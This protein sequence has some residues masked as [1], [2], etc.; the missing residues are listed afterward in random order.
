[1][2]FLIFL[3][4]IIL[5]VCFV[6]R[7][8]IGISMISCCIIYFLV[9]GGN[10][11]VI[12]DTVMNQL[13]YNSVLIAAPLFIFTANIMNSSK[14]TQH[15]FTFCKA[16]VGNKRGAMGYINIII[17]LIF[18][19]MSGFA[20]ADVSG[21][22]TLELAEMKKD[23]YDT[24]FSCA[25]TSATAVVG[26]IFP[27]SI[28]MVLYA[29]IAGVSVGKL[30]MGGMI[31]AVLICIV[32]G[33][34]VWYISKK[35]NYPRGVKFT[36]KQFLKYTLKALP[37]LMTPVILLG[38]IYTGIVTPTEAGALAALYTIIISLFA[39]RTLKFRSFI[40]T[41][42]DTI[43][44]TGVIIAIVIGAYVLQYVVTT[45]GMG[46]VVSN[47][48]LS[49][50]HNKYVFLLIVNVLFLLLGMFFETSIPLFVFVPLIYPVAT[51]LGIDPIHFGV[52][53]IVNMMLGGV[54][55]PFGILAFITSGLSGEPLKSIFKEIIPM[56]LM[57]LIVL[58]LI[59][60]IPVLITGLPDL[61]M[62]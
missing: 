5:A 42:K 23:G 3:P 6:I 34:Y 58:L 48:V 13:Y 16:L 54:T 35:R 53:I 44:Q 31:P 40:K 24:G 22:G 56:A 15:M 11:S 46:G 21:I 25:I 30:F 39:Y 50:T 32:L 57:M 8:P 27:P 10:L 36:F 60:Y 43:I 52:V 2:N 17:S 33:V 62:S 61:L 20:I 12:S 7:A 28:P 38:G 37:A 29:M 45:S 9:T 59:T 1:M 47:W 4:L 19:G 49:L 14:V 18:S 55:P 26:P 41:I 51:A